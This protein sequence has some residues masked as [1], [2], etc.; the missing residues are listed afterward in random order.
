MHSTYNDNN[1]SIVPQQQ[2]NQPVVPRQAHTDAQLIELWL[3]GRSKHTQRAYR[4]DVRQ[5]F[6]RADKRLHDLTL[7]DIQ[8]F[9]DEL[10]R[11]PLA[12]ATNH[13]KLSAIKSLLSFGHRLGYLPYDTGR[14]LRLPPVRET[15]SER[16]LSEAEVNRMLALEPNPRNQVILTL[17]Y[18]SGV[19]V[20][21]LCGLKWRDV[22]ERDDAEGQISV[23]GKGDKTR[24]ILL[25]ASV[26]NMIKTLQEEDARD[27]S[28][29]FKSRKGGHLNP[30]QVWRI[31]RKAALRAGI[32]KAVSCHWM[33]H[34]HGSHSL[35]RGCPISLVQSTL[36]H[37]SVA[38][39]GRYLHARPT[40]SSANYLNL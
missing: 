19:R 18:S 33:R 32:E 9:A 36:G 22:Q 28:P 4:A 17:L 2:T 39:T 16:I 13:R 34:A 26:W 38:T 3:H 6:D 21:E 11:S 12:S 29:V 25:P 1:E 31:V 40:D 14:P 30:S 27:E 5:F 23:F 15:L 24:A 20:S 35:D 10:E 7:G 37:A 8:Q